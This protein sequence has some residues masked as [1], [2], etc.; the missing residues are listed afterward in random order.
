MSRVVALVADGI[1]K[2]IDEFAHDAALGKFFHRREFCREVTLALHAVIVF[3]FIGSPFMHKIIVA[4]RRAIEIDRLEVREELAFRIPR[5][6]P[7]CPFRFSAA[8][9]TDVSFAALRAF[10]AG[11]NRARKLTLR[12]IGAANKFSRGT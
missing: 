5:A 3:R 10:D 12:I 7:E 1:E 4:A 6:S 11:G 9:A 2:L 8:S